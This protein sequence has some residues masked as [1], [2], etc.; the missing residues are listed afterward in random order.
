ML[1]LTVEEEEI[2]EHCG[3]GRDILVQN[4]EESQIAVTT[5]EEMEEDNEGME[6]Q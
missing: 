1:R 5:L 6:I 2:Y 3:C 4:G